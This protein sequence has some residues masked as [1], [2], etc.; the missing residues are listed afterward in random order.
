[1]LLDRVDGFGDARQRVAH[2]VG[3]AAILLVHRS[4]E[5]DR[6]HRIEFLGAR[7]AR[8]G[9]QRGEI[10]FGHRD[11]REYSSPPQR[12]PI[13]PLDRDLVGFGIDQEEEL[14]RLDRL[15]IDDRHLDDAPG[16]LGRE[17]H[18][19]CLDDGLPR[20]G[21]QAISDQRVAE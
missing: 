9:Q 11:A 15:I 10:R 12:M 21:R 8:L 16:D 19:E 5:V 6:R 17:P 14:T 2:R 1:M 3:D 18:D 4:H 20:I 7:V 13:G